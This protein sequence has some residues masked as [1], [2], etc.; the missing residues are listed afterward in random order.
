MVPFRSTLAALL[1]LGS[2]SAGFAADALSDW[3]SW[4]TNL[5][6]WSANVRQ[7][8]TLKSLAQPVTTTGQVW[9][10][11]P[12]LFRWE[13]GN[14]P[15]TIAIR[16]PDRLTLL[17]PVLE[18]AEIY[19][20]T[21]DTQGPWRDSLALLEA[22]FPR[23]RATLDSRFQILELRTNAPNLEIALQ[24]KSRAAR[25]WMR[26][27]EITVDLRNHVLLA[28]DLTFADGSRL[29]NEFMDAAI[30]PSIPADRFRPE[31][32]PGYLRSEPAKP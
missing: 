28:T 14:P 11:A 16:D 30:N 20:L 9:F 24:P 1:T 22:G 26:R 21:E 17:Y 4:Q 12:N 5:L 19:R 15:R 31:I 10:C 23:D 32:P 27:I 29:R 25:R 6:T 3:L 7:I 18:R 2:A 8:R 13:L